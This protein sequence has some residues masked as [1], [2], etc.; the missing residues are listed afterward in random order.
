MSYCPLLHHVTLQCPADFLHFLQ[1]ENIGSPDG[2]PIR[3]VA[4]QHVNEMDHFKLFCEMTVW[5]DHV[6]KLTEMVPV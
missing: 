4:V 2:D 3:H 1:N 6:I 5:L